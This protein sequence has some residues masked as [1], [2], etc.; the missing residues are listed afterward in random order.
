MFQLV[1]DVTDKLGRRDIS[2]EFLTDSCE[3]MRGS[4]VSTL[5]S[6]KKTSPEEPNEMG[7]SLMD[8]H[9]RGKA[10]HFADNDSDFEF[11]G[12]AVS[13]CVCVCV[14]ARARACVC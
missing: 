7:K 6:D 11:C 4:S 1:K 12:L 2:D 13:V 14:C 3:D 9:V 5:E 8:Q 10:R